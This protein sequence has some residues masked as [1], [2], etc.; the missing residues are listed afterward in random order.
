MRYFILA[1][2]LACALAFPSATA[3]ASCRTDACWERVHE[4]RAWNWCERHPRCLWRHRFKKLDAG[5]RYWYHR[6]ARCE[7]YDANRNTKAKQAR[8]DTGNGYKG[9]VQF[10]P[11]TW[12][13][14]QRYLP[15]RWRFYGYIPSTSYEHQGVVAIYLARAEGKFHW[16]RCGRH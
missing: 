2:L 9:S 4:K 5:W 11:S 16:P 3:Q 13:A 8:T 10:L 15:A 1:V 6:T 14:A 7:S 12:N